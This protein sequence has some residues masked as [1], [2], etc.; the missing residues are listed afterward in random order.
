MKQPPCCDF[1]SGARAPNGWG[2][3]MKLWPI[4][5]CMVLGGCTHS[6]SGPGDNPQTD[7]QDF[8]TV[9]DDGDLGLWIAVKSTVQSYEVTSSAGVDELQGAVMVAP[10]IKMVETSTSA[11]IHIDAADLI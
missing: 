3:G 11:R 5:T 8:E 6:A 1:G 4:I 2:V 10:L 7:R 9:A